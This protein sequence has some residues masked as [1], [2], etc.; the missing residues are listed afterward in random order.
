MAEVS[1][2]TPSTLSGAFGKAFKYFSK[3]SIQ[4]RYRID[5]VYWVTERIKGFLWSKQREVLESVAVHKRTAV[6]SGHGVGKSRI[7]SI[8]AEWWIDSHADAIDETIVITTAPSDDQVKGIIWEYI[9]KDWRAHNL[10]GTVSEKAEWKAD[11]RDIV[12]R[13]RKPA[14]GNSIS[15]QGRH[16]KYC[17]VIIDEACGVSRELFDVAEAITTTDTCRVLAI[18]N[19][20]DPNTFFGTIFLK[21]AGL[22]D[23][24]WNKLTISVL[25]S[26]NFTGEECPPDVSSQLTS[27]SYESDLLAR[28]GNDK[29]SSEYKSRV[30]GEF[31]EFSEN[32][33]YPIQL[34][35]SSVD[36]VLPPPDIK[37]APVLGVDVARF[38]SDFSTIVKF[39]SGEVTTIG[40][41]KNKTGPALAAIVHME[42]QLHKVS[43]VR[44]DATGVGASALDALAELSVDHGYVVIGMFGS[45]SSPDSKRWLNARAA[46]HD[47]VRQML[48][49]KTLKLP[50]A[51]GNPD[52]QQLFDEMIEIRYKINP[53]YQSMQIESKDDMARRGIKSPDFSDALM[54]AAAE[55]DWQTALAGEEIGNTMTYDPFQ[56][57]EL[58]E[59][60]NYV[61]SPV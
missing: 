52:A 16:Y 20:T 43:E 49:A 29:T 40:K 58:L 51:V 34:L 14:D 27:L 24:S 23:A 10:I 3:K 48:N 30:L 46:W 35:Y 36:I 15:F 9:R 61:I 4:A 38:G 60:H 11:N 39:D 21:N 32:T 17:L 59:G 1:G 56:D 54:Y 2:R 8:A 22:G 41:Y 28:N 6:K 47:N 18:G 31:P 53:T 45:A 57:L 25:D 7:A 42:A 13:G 37:K 5:P 26:P 33:L 50:S 19:P 55:V 12:G 44:I